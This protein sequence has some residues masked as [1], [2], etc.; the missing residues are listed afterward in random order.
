[1]ENT[2]LKENG[3]D[4]VDGIN[5]Q[6]AVNMGLLQGFGAG[7]GGGF[8]GRGGGA[9]CGANYANLATL[10]H[11]VDH[12]RGC[13]REGNEQ[14]LR[15]FS[16]NHISDQFMQQNN[17]LGQ[18]MLQ[19]TREMAVSQAATAKG[20]ADQALE[21]CKCCKDNEILTITEASKTRELINSNELRKAVDANNISATVGG[22]N[23]NANQNTAAI[24]QAIQS[25]PSGHHHGH[26]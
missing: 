1:M 2:N 22:I 24:I 19:I 5:T 11:G 23:A 18:Y 26:P 3:G 7:C 21:F 15:S 14:V 6:D 10:Q 4:K 8:F 13:V 12:T 20:F 17:T 16:E 9:D 25:I